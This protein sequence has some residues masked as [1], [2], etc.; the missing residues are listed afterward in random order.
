M[1]TPALNSV[2]Q[3]TFMTA[4]GTIDVKSATNLTTGQALLFSETTSVKR[5]YNC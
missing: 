1:G 2:S 5:L 3:E 4:F